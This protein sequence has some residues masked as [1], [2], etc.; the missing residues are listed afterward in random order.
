MVGF[1]LSPSM[2]SLVRIIEKG[3]KTDHSNERLSIIKSTIA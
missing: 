1:S 2:F 3:K